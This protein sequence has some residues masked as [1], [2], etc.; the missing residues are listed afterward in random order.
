[1]SQSKN[2]RQDKDI[3][4]ISVK[5]SCTPLEER[6]NYLN[7]KDL[8]MTAAKNGTDSKHLAMFTH[9]RSGY[10]SVPVQLFLKF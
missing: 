6:E 5:L 7:K 1:M 4:L 8:M 3:Y 10:M 9:D 2:H